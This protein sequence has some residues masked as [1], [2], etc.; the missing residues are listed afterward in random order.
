MKRIIVLT[1]AVLAAAIPPV[2][3]AATKTVDITRN[4]F[5][6]DRLTIDPGDTV[7]WTNKDT[8]A[9]SVIADGAAFTSSPVLQSNQSYSYTF[10]RS[11]NFGYRDGTKTNERGTII[12]RPGV[13]MAVAPAAIRFGGAT[14]LSGFVSSGATGESV[15]IEAQQ[16]GTTTFTRVG[17]ANSTGNGAWSFAVKPTINTTYQVRWRTATSAKLEVKVM[18]AVALT[19]V[20]RGRFTTRITAAQSFVGKYVVLQRYATV[21][22]RWV[23]VKR[24]VLR[25]ATVPAGQTVSA[26]TF[27]SSLRRGTRRRVVLPQSQAGTCYLAARSGTVRA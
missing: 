18:P 17:S 7:T 6:P 15:T 24:V 1:I 26:A 3:Q 19:K 9:H 8:V 2:A 27:T 13:T 5:V 4:G 21:R 11:G 23:S 12:V 25:T 14:T 16:C 10:T 22:R 20:R